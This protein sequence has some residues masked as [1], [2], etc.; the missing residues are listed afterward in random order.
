M[1]R[2]S[3]MDK[4]M[5]FDDLAAQGARSS[6]FYPEYLGLVIKNG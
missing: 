3:Y 1:S 4:N 6:R 5:T 2:L